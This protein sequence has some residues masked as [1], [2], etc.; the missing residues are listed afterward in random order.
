MG[1]CM[2]PNAYR[3]FYFRPFLVLTWK[4][5]QFLIFLIV[6][7]FLVEQEIGNGS[8]HLGSFVVQKTIIQIFVPSHD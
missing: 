7:P 8:G 5:N 4:F 2:G 1:S 3:T 6:R